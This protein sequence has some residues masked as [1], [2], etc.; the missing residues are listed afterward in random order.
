MQEHVGAGE[1]YQEAVVRGF[2]E[3]LGIKLDINNLEY[4][5]KLPPNKDLYYFVT[6]FR[7]RTD[8]SPEYN[9]TDFV[10]AE[11]IKPSALIKKLEAGEVAKKSLL[12]TVRLLIKF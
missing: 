1:T 5:G 4:I 8:K 9:P 11:W 10:E 3:E 12:P 6:L 2:A 7:Y